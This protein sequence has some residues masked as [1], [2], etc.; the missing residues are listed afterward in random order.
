MAMEMMTEGRIGN[1][2]MM[3]IQAEDIPTTLKYIRKIWREMAEDEP[4]ETFFL[5][6]EFDQA[7]NQE[8]KLRTIYGIFAMLAI[9]IA[10]LGLL[11]LASYAAERKTKSIGI[12][13]AMGSTVQSIVY[14][15]TREFVQWV[16][17]SNLIAWP[18]AYFLM[19]NWLQDYPFRI[20]LSIWLFLF[21]AL[22]SL[23]IAT[24]TVI[25]KSY[26]AASTNPA[27]SLRYE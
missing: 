15:L 13:K 3:R 23:V 21:A 16:L 26:R 4:F 18:A 22:A 24:L 7:Y 9:F 8:R 20:G 14:M 25:Y 12:R 27:E 19:K 17:I 1:Y 11:G 10:C 5:D 2:L 6:E